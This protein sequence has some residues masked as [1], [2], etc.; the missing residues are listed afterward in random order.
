MASR[1]RE[2]SAANVPKWTVDDA[3]A[4]KTKS[5]AKAKQKSPAK[6]PRSKGGAGYSACQSGN[7][8]KP[9]MVSGKQSDTCGS[10]APGGDGATLKDLCF[11]DKR[12]LA[13]LVKE[14]A[15]VT[16]S[17]ELAIVHL[18]EERVNFERKLS[19]LKEH[20]DTLMQ[21][22][23][24]VELQYRQSQG[25]LQMYR[26]QLVSQEGALAELQL[27][28]QGHQ[29]LSSNTTVMA[30]AQPPPLA[31]A[32]AGRPVASELLSSCQQQRSSG[33]PLPAGSCSQSSLHKTTMISRDSHTGPLQEAALHNPLTTM[34]VCTDVSN[35]S[36]GSSIK[37][38]SDAHVPHHRAPASCDIFNSANSPPVTGLNSQQQQQ[39]CNTGATHVGSGQSFP[40][41]SRPCDGCKSSRRVATT[42]APTC[43]S[44]SC[45]SFQSQGNS[46]SD[47]AHERLAPA[48]RQRR[49]KE[50]VKTSKTDK[51]N[52]VAN[53]QVQ[54]V[55][56]TCRYSSQ[57]Q[58]VV[59]PV[60]PPHQDHQDSAMGALASHHTEAVKASIPPQACTKDRQQQQ[61]LHHR[62]PHH[63]PCHREET[64]PGSDAALHS[65]S[66]SSWLPGNVCPYH[67]FIQQQ[68]VLQQQQQS[69]LQALEK[70]LSLP[71]PGSVAPADKTG[72]CKHR[73]ARKKNKK[74]ADA[75]AYPLMST[76]PSAL[77]TSNAPHTKSEPGNGGALAASHAPNHGSHC[78]SKSAAEHGHSKV[79]KEPSLFSPASKLSDGCSVVTSS[80]SSSSSSSSSSSPVLKSC[81]LS[82]SAV[83][84]QP[85]SLKTTR[86]S[87]SANV[88]Q[89]KRHPPSHLR[90]TISEGSINDFS[91]APSE[92]LR[93]EDLGDELDRLEEDLAVLSLLNDRDASIDRCS[94]D[95][96]VS[97]ASDEAN[98]LAL[99]AR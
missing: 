63:Q 19:E 20:H 8:S 58:V 11:D 76:D 16:E 74:K 56:R 6:A 72:S 71:T 32:T 48:S 89:H 21:S 40:Q 95:R 29:H 36:S 62:H 69:Q 82:T 93:V 68:H 57:S 60:V 86:T 67:Q 27:Q 78:H 83:L 49:P 7:A 85:D 34:H 96:A 73:H 80:T 52:H 42:T 87:M 3:G 77:A 92:S 33:L 10:P 45:A 14:L 66:P 5:K 4:K 65:R 23:E 24:G 15:D 75:D 90:S 61:H 17:R 46:G 13:A 18:Q 41:C 91:L 12:R 97:S 26:N 38:M 25:L 59:Q 44:S 9:A 35:S 88:Q 2:N 53:P 99:D 98:L 37:R 22:R 94:M 54:S 51:S 1:L 84:V 81:A 79:E 47:S 43:S 50:Y 31:H 70:L 64:G 39:H 28:Q 55:G 30:S